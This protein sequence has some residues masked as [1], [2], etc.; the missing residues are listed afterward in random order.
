MARY[1]DDS[2]TSGKL[3]AAAVGAVAGLA[4]GVLVAQKF[5]GFE[6]IRSRIRDRFGAGGPAAGDEDIDL[7]TLR[8]FEGDTFADEALG[9]EFEDDELADDEED[10]ETA[11][12]E[13]RVL[14]AFV[15]DPV[16]RERAVDIGAL[17]PSVIELSG[18]VLT[19]A[20]RMRATAVAKGI[21]GVLTVVNELLVGDPDGAEIP[22]IAPHA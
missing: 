7:D 4:L 5:G 12:L 14:K 21:P 13:A 2:D 19:K 16:F 20:E 10:A 9:E 15:A 18:W 3:I 11:A 22:D 17:E 6:G 8:E 1:R